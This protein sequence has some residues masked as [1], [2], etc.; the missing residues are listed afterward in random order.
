MGISLTQGLLITLLGVV[1]SFLLVGLASLAGQKGSTPTLVLSRAAFGIKGNR[2]P[3]LVS[4][5]LLVGWETSLCSLAPT[6]WPRG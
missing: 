2:L 5:L 4:W 1:A 3:V 6:A